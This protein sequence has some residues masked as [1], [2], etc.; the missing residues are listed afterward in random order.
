[1]TLDQLLHRANAAADQMSQD[2]DG[3]DCAFEL[4]GGFAARR[5][6]GTST[7]CTKRLLRREPARKV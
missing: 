4:S 6:L 7:T 2:D 1:M 3:T 5:P